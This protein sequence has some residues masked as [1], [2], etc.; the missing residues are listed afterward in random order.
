M[1]E[2][3]GVIIKELRTSKKI[4]SE[5]LYKG[6]LSRQAR[7]NFEKG[8]NDTTVNKFFIMLD[9]LNISLEEFYVAFTQ[10]EDVELHLF[11]NI[12]P[13]FYSKDKE[14]LDSLVEKL[15]REYKK[16]NNVKYL[17]YR[18]MAQ[19][20]LSTLNNEPKSTEFEVLSNYLINCDSWGYYEIMLF[21]NSLNY[22]SQQL[23]DTVFKRVQHT[24]KKYYMMQRY[25][26]E[27][28]MLLLNIIY[29]NLRDLNISQVQKYFKEYDQ[30]NQHLQNDMYYQSM[31]KFFYE[32]I[33]AC[34][35][36]DHS[37]H[38]LEKIISYLGYFN[39]KNKQ[40]QCIELLGELNFQVKEI[41]DEERGIFFKITKN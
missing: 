32:V 17:H 25:K 22:F 36:K 29:K 9:R 19:N 27:Y 28:S 13:I 38:E 24:L 15:G 4:K 10:N 37:T 30:L 2:K 11:H 40:K 26:N 21:S 41:N 5:T 31:R 1:M 12:A 7:S 23:I 14:G 16:T 6:L 18:I 33:C 3:V 35:N 34:T 20:L 8:N 39:M